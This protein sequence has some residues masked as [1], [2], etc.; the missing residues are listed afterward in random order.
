MA[1]PETK[2]TNARQVKVGDVIVPKGWK[3]P[4]AVRSVSIVLHMSNGQDVVYTS[5]EEVDLVPAPDE[6]FIGPNL[7]ALLSAHEAAASKAMAA[8]AE[9]RA[10]EASKPGK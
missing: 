9:I 8:D 1:K 5:A 6:A 10:A 4:E 7:A 2:V 3:A